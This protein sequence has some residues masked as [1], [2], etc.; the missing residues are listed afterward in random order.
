MTSIAKI[1]GIAATSLMLVAAANAQTNN[2]EAIVSEMITMRNT[3]TDYLNKK[4]A[5]EN[6]GGNA[7]AAS[8]WQLWADSIQQSMLSMQKEIAMLKS[9]IAELEKTPAKPE[10]VDTKF[11]NILAVFYFDA[12]SA[13][14]SESD[15]NKIAELAQNNGDKVLQLVSYTDWTG[16]DQINKELSDKRAS[17]VQNSLTENGFSINQLKIY[18]KG[19]VTEAES[20]TLSPRECRRV[21]I[22]W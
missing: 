9:K 14:L 18:S 20:K 21:E 22:R 1:V 6:T 12:G 13:A 16:N 11:E 4:T 19:K 17:T 5:N 2:N 10:V 3:L 15:K 7:M 8:S